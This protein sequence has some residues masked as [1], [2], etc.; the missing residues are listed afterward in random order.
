[1]GKRVI[2]IGPA[3]PYRGGIAAFNEN[4]ASIFQSNGWDCRIFTFTQQY[5]NFLFPGKNQLT[6]EDSPPDLTIKRA[7]Y[8][9][10]PLNWL[11]ITKEIVELKPDL[12][13]TQYWMPFMA[14]AFG[15]ILRGVKKSY[16]KVF[17]ASIVHNFKPHESLIGDKQLGRFLA[18]RSDLL[19]SL[20]ANV[21]EDIRSTVPN[22]NVATLFHPIY[23]HYGKSMPQEEAR[24]DLSLDNDTQY[25]LFFGLIR[26]YKGLDTLIECLPLIKTEKKFKLII[27]GE[28]YENESKYSKLIEEHNVSDIIKI[29]NQYIPNEEVPKYFCAADFVV[30][31]YKRATQSGVVPIAIHF[32]KPIVVTN[33]GGLSA[34]IENNKIGLIADATAESLAEKI[35]LCLEGNA[36]K[37]ADFAAVRTSLSWQS[38]Y[39]NFVQEIN[40][41]GFEH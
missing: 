31:P 11:K 37:D 10:N 32:E 15:T 12:L 27:A 40:D 28:F 6:T 7:I 24:A 13:I 25:I 30:L 39:N 36:F 21:A 35:S 9:T 16:P 33:V 2:F 20:S 29:V 38:F 5:P 8:S 4:M 26:A 14:P 22:K 1:M 23:D 17:T 41:N 18:N 34:V 3:Y 19:V